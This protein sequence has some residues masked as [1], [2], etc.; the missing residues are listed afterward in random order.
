M[1]S[2]TS[3]RVG[4]PTDTLV[5]TEGSGAGSDAPWLLGLVL[6]TVV[7]VVAVVALIRPMTRRR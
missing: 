6:A 3:A 2:I 7:A 1:P 4:P 5:P